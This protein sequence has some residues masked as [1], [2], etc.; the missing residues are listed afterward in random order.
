MGTAL[1]TPIPRIVHYSADE[2]LTKYAICEI[3]AH[4]LHLP[5][6]HIIR[7]SAVPKDAVTRPRD[8]HLSTDESVALVGDL[9]CTRFQDWWSTHLSA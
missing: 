6:D 7:D 9:G 8:C 1:D 5:I 2:C 3:F 4:I